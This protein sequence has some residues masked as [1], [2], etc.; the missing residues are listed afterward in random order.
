MSVKSARSGRVS[1]REKQFVSYNF[2]CKLL[3]N[4][5]KVMGEGLQALA[6]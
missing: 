6:M 4:L 5:F 1:L 3:F 2:V